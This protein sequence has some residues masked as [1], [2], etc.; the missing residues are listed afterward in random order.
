MDKRCKHRTNDQR[1]LVDNKEMSMD[2]CIKS[3]HFMFRKLC[4]Q[5]PFEHSTYSHLPVRG[6]CE[7]LGMSKDSCFALH[8]I[9]ISNKLS[10]TWYMSVHLISFTEEFC[11]FRCILDS[12]KAIF[13]KTWAWSANPD[14]ALYMA[15][16]TWEQSHDK[17]SSWK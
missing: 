10:T 1:I 7:P 8:E 13:S 11:G 3:A 16:T 2:V 5:F 9:D 12:E 15:S 6:K 4:R 14:S 17:I